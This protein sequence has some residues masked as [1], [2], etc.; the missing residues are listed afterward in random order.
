[1]VRIEAAPESFRRVES[2]ASIALPSAIRTYREFAEDHL[3][4]SSV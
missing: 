4:E 1:M 2:L 3:K